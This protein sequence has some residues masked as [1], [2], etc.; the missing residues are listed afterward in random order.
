MPNT[1]PCRA[2]QKPKNESDE[3][4]RDEEKTDEASDDDLDPA[5]AHLLSA[6]IRL[7]PGLFAVSAEVPG[8]AVGFHVHFQEEGLSAWTAI[9]SRISTCHRT[10]RTVSPGPYMLS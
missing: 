9:Q 4:G 3:S 1:A 10:Q 6:L 5:I 2:T 8:A 7:V